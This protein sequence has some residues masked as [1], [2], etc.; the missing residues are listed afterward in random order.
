MFGWQAL[1]AR[2]AALAAWGQRVVADAIGADLGDLPVHP[3]V[4]MRIVP[5]P[6]GV[7]TTPAAARELQGRIAVEAGC[8][9]AVSAWRGQGLL[10]VSGQAYNRTTEYV[11]LA[12]AL[13]GVLAGMP[14][15]G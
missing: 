15:Q 14:T 8:E 4:S 12:D 3:A 11:R 5:L 13:P 6:A 2:N 7:A 9:V 10:R 1:R